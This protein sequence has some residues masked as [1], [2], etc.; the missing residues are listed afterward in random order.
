MEMASSEGPLFLLFDAIAYADERAESTA[1][2]A[3]IE[4]AE[5]AGVR[6]KILTQ[7]EGG[8]FAHVSE[9]P[10]G[11]TVDLHRH[12]HDEFFIVVEGSC[13]FLPDGST[14]KG[15][16]SALLRAGY[17]YGFV[18]GPDGLRFFNIRRAKTSIT[19]AEPDA[20]GVRS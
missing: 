10:A 4:A 7:G 6:R 2:I 18:A 19:M 5:R 13:T 14:L 3:L 11:Y 8:Y 9:F 15:S 17:Q 1:P 12:D 16:D 20:H